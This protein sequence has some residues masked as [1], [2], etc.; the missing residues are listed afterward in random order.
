MTDTTETP[1]Q[2]MENASPHN[3]AL[4]RSH[5]EMA[6]SEPAVAPAPGDGL[7][8]V[9]SFEIQQGLSTDPTSL[10]AN[11]RTAKMMVQAELSSADEAQLGKAAEGGTRAAH[12]RAR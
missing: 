11:D 12:I 4:K 5:S 9:L 10:R 3:R 7:G 2:T 6:R 1:L 8:P